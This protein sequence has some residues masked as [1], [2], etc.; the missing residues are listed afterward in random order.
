VWSDDRIWLLWLRFGD[1][2]DDRSP[3]AAGGVNINDYVNDKHDHINKY[4]NNH[5]ASSY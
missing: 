4:D 3:P 2:S 5:N 1:C